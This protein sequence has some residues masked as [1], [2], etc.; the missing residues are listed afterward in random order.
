MSLVRLVHEVNVI[1]E[2]QISNILSENRFS[3][4]IL[5]EAFMEKHDSAN[6][7]KIRDFLNKDEPLFKFLIRGLLRHSFL[8]ESV[9]SES[10]NTTKIRTRWSLND[11]DPRKA[12]YEAC[13]EILNHLIDTIDMSE[14]TKMF[15]SFCYKYSVLPYE[16]PINFRHTIDSSIHSAQNC[17]WDFS[18]DTLKVLKLRSFLLDPASNEECVTFSAII[19]DKIKVKVYLT[20]RVLTGLFKTNREKRW[21]VH[22]KSV[23]FAERTACFQIEQKLV[24]QLCNFKNFPV[25]LKEKLLQHDL[26]L[27]EEVL[28]CPITFEELDFEDFKR[29][30]LDPTWGKSKFQVGHLHPLKAF[31]VNQVPGHNA[32]NISWVTADGNRLQGHLTIEEWLALLESIIFNKNSQNKLRK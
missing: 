4:K 27:E 6:L 2:I 30:V 18:D 8:I 26:L 15:L 9:S 10:V 24:Q 29:S 25:S 14:R 7:I 16:L 17:F 13:T 5:T 3:M 22:P 11:E 32:N 19:K 21:E 20:D 28:R 31:N 12:S 23:H 1:S